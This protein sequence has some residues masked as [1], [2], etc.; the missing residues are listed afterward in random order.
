MSITALKYVFGLKT[1]PNGEPL[2]KVG[3]QLMALIAGH[4]DDQKGIAGVPFEHL[5]K[6]LSCPPV[7]A[8]R[9]IEQ[10]VATGLVEIVAREDEQIYFRIR[11]LAWEPT[12]GDLIQPPPNLV[13]VHNAAMDA[14]PAIEQ[15]IEQAPAPGGAALLIGPLLP[16]EEAAAPITFAAQPALPLATEATPQTPPT[17]ID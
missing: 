11:G 9:F 4:Y 7:V 12:A 6:Y 10:L 5:R 1:A 15:A 2:K 3:L 8:E 14:D 16:L 17:P 13:G